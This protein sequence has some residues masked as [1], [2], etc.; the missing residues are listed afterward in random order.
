MINLKSKMLIAVVASL[1]KL[2][3][4]IL[5]STAIGTFVFS[6]VVAGYLSTSNGDYGFDLL[7]IALIIAGFGFFLYGIL[8]SILWLLLYRYAIPKGNSELKRHSISAV[9]ASLICS[10]LTT[11]IQGNEIITKN[12]V[13]GSLH[14]II[15][16]LFCIF[17]FS[18]LF[19]RREIDT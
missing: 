14:N 13:Q 9:L 11:A 7:G 19:L 1:M 10:V 3:L 6:L 12:F 15:A 4:K 5:I 16:V 2:Y 17:I 18:L 8:G